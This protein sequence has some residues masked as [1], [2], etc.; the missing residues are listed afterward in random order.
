MNKL[1]IESGN[2]I[3]QENFNKSNEANLGNVALIHIITNITNDALK[4]SQKVCSKY[5]LMHL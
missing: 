4:I 1:I 3:D 5:I 2:N